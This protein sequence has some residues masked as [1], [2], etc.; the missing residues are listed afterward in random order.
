MNNEEEVDEIMQYRQEFMKFLK[1]TNFIDIMTH[2]QIESALIIAR[3]WLNNKTAFYQPARC[4][5]K[6]FVKFVATQF[7][8]RMKDKEIQKL[9]KAL[10]LACEDIFENEFVYIEKRQNIILELVE[11]FKT[12][13]K[14]IVNN[15]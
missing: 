4:D 7:C 11:H 6:Q 12:K 9:N 2:N 10:E 13:A 1:E 15:G 5:Q 8:W 14:E 3:S